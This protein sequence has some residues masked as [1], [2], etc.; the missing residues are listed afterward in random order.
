MKKIFLIFAISVLFASCS[1]QSKLINTATFSKSKATTPLTVLLA[2][3]Q[4]SPEKISYLYIP[5]KSVL[6]GGHDNV[7]NSAVSEALIA[8]GNA[9]VLVSLEHQIKYNAENQIE[10]ILV[11]GY[12]AKYINFRS[13]SEE[14][15]SKYLQYNNS[16]DEEGD[17]K[18]IKLF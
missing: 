6:S 5:S 3:L 13:P 18:K 17:S 9:D 2:D 4:V 10:S 16:S 11:T 8:N 15:L 1:T 12:P 14:N 7:I